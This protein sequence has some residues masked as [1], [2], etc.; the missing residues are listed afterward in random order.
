MFGFALGSSFV[1]YYFVQYLLDNAK[2]IALQYMQYVL[3][4]I[5][6]SG[7]ISFAICYRFGPLTDPRSKNL[8]RWSLK[9]ISLSIFILVCRV[10][11]V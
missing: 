9:V 10:V 11:H 7:V 5:A 4:Y 6:V 2:M 1:S 3:G 8:I